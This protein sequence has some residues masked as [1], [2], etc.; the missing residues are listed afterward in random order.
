MNRAKN[1][2]RIPGRDNFEPMTDKGYT[3][4]KYITYNNV[5]LEE[6]SASNLT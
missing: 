3:E 6:K 2:C 5:G 1:K 4:E